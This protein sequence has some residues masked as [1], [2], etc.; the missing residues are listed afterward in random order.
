MFRFD[1]EQIVLDVAGLKIGGQP[2]EYP[3]VIAGTIFYGGHKIISDEKAGVFDKDKAEGLIKMQEEMSDEMCIR[4]RGSRRNK[5]SCKLRFRYRCTFNRL[6]VAC[7]RYNR[8]CSRP[9]SRSYYW[10]VNCR[11]Y[12]GIHPCNGSRWNSCNNW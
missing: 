11:P 1:K 10:Y 9:C 8:C 2:G 12:N 3:T 4:D 7:N 5:N 6:H